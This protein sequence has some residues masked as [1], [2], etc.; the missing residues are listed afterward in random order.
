MVAETIVPKNKILCALFMK[1]YKVNDNFLLPSDLIQDATA[2]YFYINTR[3]PD[4][5]PIVILQY[6]SIVTNLIT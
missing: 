5:F 3:L 1:R 2:K 6:R 4:L